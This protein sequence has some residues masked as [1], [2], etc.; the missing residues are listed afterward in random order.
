MN[1]RYYVAAALV[2]GI[3][4]FAWGSMVH[5][6][7]V[8]PGAEPKAFADSN[9]VVEVIKANAP[10]NGI[11]FEGRGVFA[12]VAFRPDMG[13]KFT[14][15]LPS[16]SI[17]LGIEIAVALLLAWVLLRLPPL[18]A[19]QTGT[20][21]AIIGVAAA[22]EELLPMQLWYGFPRANTAFEAFGLIVG[23]FLL[24]LVLGALRNRMIPAQSA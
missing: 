4:S 17:Q 8:F 14:S 5:L 22:I 23:W 13:P 16:L 21:L 9:A 3:V 20:L 15:I 11:Y 24:G 18:T 12:A 10:E 19:F 2:G 6:L 1:A 7:P